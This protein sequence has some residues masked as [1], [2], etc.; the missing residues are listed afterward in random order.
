M[1]NI[2][3]IIVNETISTTQQIFGLSSTDKTSWIITHLIYL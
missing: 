3:H 2:E 1:I